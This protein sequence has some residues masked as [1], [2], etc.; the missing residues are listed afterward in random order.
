MMDSSLRWNDKDYGFSRPDY[1][2]TQNDRL[3]EANLKTMSAAGRG[4]QWY[5]PPPR[6]S[7]VVSLPQNDICVAGQAE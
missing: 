4:L 2:G 7:S 5:F 1:I 3:V 6:D